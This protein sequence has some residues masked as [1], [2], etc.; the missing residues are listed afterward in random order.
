MGCS[1]WRCQEKDTKR[2]MKSPGEGCG[3]WGSR[4]TQTRPSLD[5]GW[6]DGTLRCFPSLAKLF[7]RYSREENSPSTTALPW[8]SHSGHVGAAPGGAGRGNG[9][10]NTGM[11]PIPCL[12]SCHS[13]P[14]AP[15]NRGQEPASSGGGSSQKPGSGE[16][17]KKK[18]K[19]SKKKGEKKKEKKKEEVKAASH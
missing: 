19:K 10:Q 11:C 5:Q 14:Q 12:T 2:G 6:D 17:G 18:E 7:S 4:V 1:P 13:Q 3:P 15:K 16:R 9:H 8:P